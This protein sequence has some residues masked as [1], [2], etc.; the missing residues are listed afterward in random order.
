[1]VTPPTL[2]PLELLERSR[3]GDP[4]G[5]ESIEAFIHAW[6]GGTV[7]DAQVAAWCMAVCLRGLDEGQTAALTRAMIA[8]GDRLE[9]GK[10]GPVVDKHSTGGVGDATTLVVAP[11]A[12]RVAKMSGR[13]LG[14]TGGTLDK[15]E[16]IPGYRVDLP[17]EDFVRQVRDVGVA[18]TGANARLVPADK[19][20][21]AL[22]DTTGTVQSPALIAS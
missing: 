14:H 4:V 22:R 21:Y 12:V 11:L 18:V 10:L 13:G 15:L 17:L 8:S 2:A 19:R 7:S 3:R 6:L 20:L 1:M 16:A 5:P 9:L